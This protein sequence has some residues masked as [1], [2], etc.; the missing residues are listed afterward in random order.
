MLF[1]LVMEK[2]RSFLATS[3]RRGAFKRF[4]RFSIRLLKP[5]LRSRGFR[6]INILHH[7]SA[8]VGSTLSA[9]SYPERIRYRSREGG[10][11]VICVEG[12]MATQLQHLAPQIIDRIN[13]YFGDEVVVR[14]KI[15]QTREF[16]SAPQRFSVEPSAEGLAATEERLADME[17]GALKDALLRLG[18]HIYDRDA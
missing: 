15:K 11:L 18:A 14:L 10:E 7:W 16:C 17:S 9:F 6:G 2:T 12:A 1:W 13:T 8:I 5:L 3:S 4:D